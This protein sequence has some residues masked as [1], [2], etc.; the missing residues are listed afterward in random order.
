MMNVSNGGCASDATPTISVITVVRNNLEGLRLTIGSLLGQSA[1]DFEHIVIDGASEDGTPEWLSTY[2]APYN[3]SW[4]SEAD[5]GIYPAMNKGLAQA[6]GQVTLFLNGG[7]VL[8]SSEVLQT[9]SSSWQERQWKWAYG[10]ISY[11]NAE[12]KKLGFYNLEP[13][14]RRRIELGLAYVPHPST[15][16][17]TTVLQDLGGFVNDF[18]W[19]ADQELLI[20]V[21]RSYLPHVFSQGLTQFLVGGAHSQGSLGDVSRRYAKIREAHSVPVLGSAVID[22]GFTFLQGLFWTARQQLSRLAARREGI[23]NERKA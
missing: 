9:V 8:D 22:A 23:D 4:T 5:G 14:S 12:Y 20:R 2:T 13:Y 6:K 3:L 15:F 11:V 18:G 21:G 19:S 17:S 10:G 1:T 16:V 7:D